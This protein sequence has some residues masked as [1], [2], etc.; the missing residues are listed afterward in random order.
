MFNS[1]VLEVA[2]GLI[3]TFLAVSLLSGA[4]VEAIASALKWRA[5]TLLT[6]IKQLF[7]DPNFDKLSQQ[8]YAHALINP[9]GPGTETNAPAYKTKPTYIAK[10]Q[11]AN[12]MMDILGFSA[13]IAA[14]NPA[15]APQAPHRAPVDALKD[16][17][18]AK[19]SLGA[20][21]PAGGA[22]PTPAP[23]AATPASSPAIDPT[24]SVPADEQITYLLYGIIDRTLGD[25]EKIKI[26][27]S[28][29]FDNCM[30]R[31]SGVYKRWTQGVNL[32]VAFGVAVFVNV[33]T[34]TIGRAI[35]DQPTLV[36]DLK[37]DENKEAPTAQEALKYLNANLPVGWPDGFLL[38]IKTDQY[39]NPVI[40]K[41]QNGTPLLIQDQNGNPIPKKDR[42]GKPLTDT[43]GSPLYEAVYATQ[44]LWHD[45]GKDLGIA[46][47]GWLVT[48][49]ATLFGAPFWFDA[50]QKITRL[51]GSGPSPAE[52]KENV[53]AAA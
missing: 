39:G 18:K 17:V 35:W 38:E 25:L 28:N 4:I 10:D 16:A 7:N 14:I 42:T 27:L 37:A 13:A 45:D 46:A 34:I 1:T 32:V 12:A 30:D 52:K 50:L 31:V 49:V 15:P 5:S 24:A 6:G 9:R 40:Q 11:F 33:N 26:E 3:F 20:A 43:K 36:A 29:W 8:L 19:F 21:P 53:A 51:K 44:V 23:A 22:T 41:D 47:L 2:V 48:A